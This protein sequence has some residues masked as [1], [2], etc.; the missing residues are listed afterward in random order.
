[1]WIEGN[2]LILMNGTYKTQER[3]FQVMKT[4]KCMSL[5]VVASKITKHWKA[6]KQTDVC[7]FYDCLQ[8]KNPKDH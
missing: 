8:G 3:T 2:F 1:M 4:V 5:Q 6:K 7:R